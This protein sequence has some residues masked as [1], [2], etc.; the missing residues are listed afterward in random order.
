ME[1]AER[2]W[3]STVVMEASEREGGGGSIGGRER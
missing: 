3:E 2:T 1:E